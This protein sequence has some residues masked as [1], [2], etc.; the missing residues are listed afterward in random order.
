MSQFAMKRHFLD[1]I[2]GTINEQA[3]TTVIT[4][5]LNKSNVLITYRSVVKSLRR[6]AFDW[7]GVTIKNM[8]TLLIKN[9]TWG[10]SR[11]FFK[12]PNFIRSVNNIRNRRAV[13]VVHQVC[14]CDCYR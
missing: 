8:N 5:I 11:F 7:F 4:F 14:N 3:A 9:V 10:F 6:A 1:I 2:Y 13:G 12:K